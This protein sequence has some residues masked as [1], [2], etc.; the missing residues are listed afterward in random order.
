MRLTIS[1]ISTSSLST[2]AWWMCSCQW[3]FFN[4][5]IRVRLQ[6]V[7]RDETVRRTTVVGCRVSSGVL[8]HFFS[9]SSWRLWVTWACAVWHMRWIRNRS[10]IATHLVLLLVLLVE[11]ILII[12]SLNLRRFK[13]DRDEI[14][15]SCYD[16]RQT[17]AAE[18]EAESAGCPL[19]RRAHVTSLA[20]C[21]R[22]SSWFIVHPY[23][24]IIMYVNSGAEISRYVRR[25]RCCSGTCRRPASRRQSRNAIR[26]RQTTDWQKDRQTLAKS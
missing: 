4:V 23:L 13:S 10:L 1:I 24:F 3:L 7:R 5:Q 8:Q 2:H 9:F 25:P 11:V 12:K 18:Y 17:L 21:T 19:A 6:V 14:W 20:C 16:V 22:Y 15:Q 26:C